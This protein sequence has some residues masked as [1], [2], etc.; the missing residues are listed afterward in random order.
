MAVD[1]A[2]NNARYDLMGS[3]YYYLSF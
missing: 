3:H 1:I 2:V